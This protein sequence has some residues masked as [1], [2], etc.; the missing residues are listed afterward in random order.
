MLLLKIKRFPLLILSRGFLLP[1]AAHRLRIRFFISLSF[2]RDT[3]IPLPIPFLWAKKKAPAMRKVI[4]GTFN[5]SFIDFLP[6]RY[7]CSRIFA[8]HSLQYT[9]RSDFGSNGTRASPP[10]AAQVAVKNSRGPRAAFLRASRQLLQRCGSFW[11][12]RSA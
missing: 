5:V 7:H 2:F 3:Y 8:K 12:P 11:K 4:T 1:Q 10:Q 9:G 6:L